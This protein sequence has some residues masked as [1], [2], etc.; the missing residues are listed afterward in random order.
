MDEASEDMD[1][2]DVEGTMDMV[3]GREFLK[4][5][6][7]RGYSENI[8]KIEQERRRKKMQERMEAV[9]LASCACFFALPQPCTR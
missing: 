9:R 6:A 1:R 5:N 3:P 7:D 2:S 4:L 8:R